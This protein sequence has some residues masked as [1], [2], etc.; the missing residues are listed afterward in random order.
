MW[1]GV[2]MAD[3]RREAIGIIGALSDAGLLRTV[4]SGESEAAEGSEVVRMIGALREAG[5][6]AAAVGPTPPP[7]PRQEPQVGDNVWTQAIRQVIKRVEPGGLREISFM[8]KQEE[9]RWWAVE[10]R[11][12]PND[13]HWIA[14]IDKVLGSPKPSILH[15]Q[16]EVTR[17]TGAAGVTFV[18]EGKL[19]DL[20]AVYRTT[21][22]G[23]GLP[24]RPASHSGHP[25]RCGAVAHPPP[26]CL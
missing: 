16:V 22:S 11:F 5:L 18:F 14:E 13:S 20:T 10:C 19:K 9:G 23:P 21:S 1:K 24:D 15:V 25:P 3:D 8:S 4:A 6:L 17:L 2:A 7:N 26:A 12:P